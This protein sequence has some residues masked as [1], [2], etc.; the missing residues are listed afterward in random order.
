[1]LAAGLTLL[2]CAPDAQTL[3]DVRDARP[4]ADFLDAGEVRDG[5]V[6]VSDAAPPS[7]DADIVTEA[8]VCETGGL[9]GITC[10]PSGAILPNAEVSVSSLDCFGRP[11]TVQV[12][13]DAGGRFVVRGLAPG[14]AEVNVRAGR[15]FSRVTALVQAGLNSAVNG[16]S[17][18]TCL[19]ASETGLLVL[20]GDYDH[21]GDVL[22]GLGFEHDVV[23]GTRT[24]HRPARQML[25]NPEALAGYQMI[26][27]N[28]ASGIDLE[29]DNP[30]VQVL[31]ANLRAFVARG[32][33]VY[34]S[35]LA[36]DFVRRAWPDF[37]N[38][39]ARFSEPYTGE[40]CCVCTDCASE[41][42]AGADPVGGCV[43]EGSL[44]P[45]CATGGGT[46]GRGSPGLVP[47]RIVPDNLVSW[48]GAD[49]F[50]VN[51]N[52]GGWVQITSVAPSV[53]VLVADLADDRP[54]MVLFEPSPGGG[55][56][57]YTSFHN[58]AQATEAMRRIL[59][60]LIFRL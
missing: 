48:V 13:S 4:T 5:L 29:Q 53:E 44:P 45:G 28:C 38:F 33:S 31:I 58:H 3:G 20:T 14:P 60:A 56:V 17:E 27:I 55:K 11:T 21:I 32:G 23:C 2:G 15:F 19:P 8:G 9:I 7:R 6:V 10:S 51:F 1:M 34:V 52:L 47:A 36:A 42:I 24:T 40:A 26:F 35:D 50:D 22:D 30:E 16:D 41:C 12:H 18:K 46:I 49:H 37:V 43:G 57:A 25:A 39:E 59:Q 54:L